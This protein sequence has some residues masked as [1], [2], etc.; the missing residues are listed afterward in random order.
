MPTA[1]VNSLINLSDFVDF[2]LLGHVVTYGKFILIGA[3]TY[4][5]ISK[6]DLGNSKHVCTYLYT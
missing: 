1:N 2:I 4:T 5:N 6:S 3:F